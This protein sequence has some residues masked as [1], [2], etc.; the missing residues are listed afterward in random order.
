MTVT[1]AEVARHAGVSRGTVSNVMNHPELVVTATRERVTAAMQ[2]LQFIPSAHARALA[3]GR[4]RGLGLLVHDLGNPFFAEVARGVEDAA[5]AHDYVVT[6]SSTRADANRQRTSLRVML[7]Q[8]VAGVLLTPTLDGDDGLRQLRDAKTPTVLVDQEDGSDSCS[9]AVDDVTGGSLAASHLIGSG[10]R[11]FAFIGGPHR[12]Q[13]HARRLRGVKR[14]LTKQGVKLRGGLDVISVPADTMECGAGAANDFLALPTPRPTAVIAGN[15]LLAIGFMRSLVERGVR[16]PHDVALVGYDD[17]DVAALL[18][19]PLT[20]IRQ[21][22]YAIGQAA[23]ELL[24][25]EI[26]NS[27]HAHRQ[28]QFS[29][30]LVARQTSG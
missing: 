3:G 18:N 12:V 23:A 28:L 4:N 14:A 1:I 7:E 10:H 20:S 29:P 16:V 17:I 2:E 9:V 25:D 5:A 27:R 21:P 22:M 13:Q 24:I 8:R 26:E 11:R 6:A 15:D 19:V 30:E